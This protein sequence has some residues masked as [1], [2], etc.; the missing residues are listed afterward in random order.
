LSVGAKICERKFEPNVKPEVSLA[1]PSGCMLKQGRF[2]LVRNEQA[3]L[4]DNLKR[5]L[6]GSEG[7]LYRSPACVSLDDVGRRPQ[8]KACD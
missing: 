6:C 7:T 3:P 5:Q 8:R 4:L 1:K 2:G